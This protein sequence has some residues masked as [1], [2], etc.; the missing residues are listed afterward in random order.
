[1]KIYEIQEIKINICMFEKRFYVKN[2]NKRT[3]RHADKIKNTQ[4]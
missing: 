4:E 2:Y 3:K 1:M